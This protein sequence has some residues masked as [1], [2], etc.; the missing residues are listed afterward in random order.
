MLV[1]AQEEGTLATVGQPK[2]E[3]SH[4]ATILLEDIGIKRDQSARAQRLA[5]IPEET[6]KAFVEKQRAAEDEISKAG[7]VRFASSKPQKPEPPPY[8]HVDGLPLD[9]IICGDNV[10]VLGELPDES[11]DLICLTADAQV[12]PL[13][14]RLGG[15]ADRAPSR[16]PNRHQRKQPIER[17]PCPIDVEI[18]QHIPHQHF[19]VERSPIS[20]WWQRSRPKRDG[21]WG[22][23]AFTIVASSPVTS[24]NV[25]IAMFVEEKTLLS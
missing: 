22:F 24:Q 20:G 11:I 19:V 23:G 13:G 25:K 2:K 14:L 3:K 9:Q 6:I 1:M 5:G 18:L 8:V 21:G 4:G 12:T 16:T 7:L 17:L 15:W 10:Q